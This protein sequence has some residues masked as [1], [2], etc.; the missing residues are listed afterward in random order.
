MVNQKNLQ[1]RLD[2][3]IIQ[4]GQSKTKRNDMDGK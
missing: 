4:D 3:V 2:F 1:K